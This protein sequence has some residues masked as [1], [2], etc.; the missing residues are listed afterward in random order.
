M[1]TPS[2]GADG[3][4]TYN[5]LEITDMATAIG[6]YEGAMDGALVDLY[7]QIHGMFDDH[8]WSG[9]AS[10][11]CGHAFDECHRGAGKIKETLG[12]VASALSLSG[13]T[14]Q[15]LDDSIARSMTV[16]F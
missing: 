11:A 16:N 4:I 6:T 7:N 9:G 13:Q 2:F 10:Q 5:F 12:R 1:G 14:I 15:D 3:R 8:D